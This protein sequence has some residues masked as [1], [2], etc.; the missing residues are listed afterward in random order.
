MDVDSR[1]AEFSVLSEARSAPPLR[2]SASARRYRAQG[3]L[4]GGYGS[5]QTLRVPLE[6]PQRSLLAE[7]CIANRGSR[8]VDLLG[9]HEA[10]TASRP[11][12]RVDG[13]EVAPDLTLR[14][15]ADESGSVVG[16]LDSLVDRMSAF[17]PPVFEK[18]VLWLILALVVLVLPSAA[19]YA[20]VSGF[21]ADE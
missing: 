8:K 20:L 6:P 18:P 19:L 3:D 5:P 17:H 13:V 14:F 16:R 15:L 11:I 21:R 7:F 4:D 12:A 1:I 2:V 10:R 9:A